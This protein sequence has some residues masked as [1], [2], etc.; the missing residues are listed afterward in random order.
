MSCSH[1][2]YSRHKV[3][4]EADITVPDYNV[5]EETSGLLQND[6]S[7]TLRTGVQ[8]SSSFSSPFQQVSLQCTRATGFRTQPVKSSSRNTAGSMKRLK[9]AFFNSI[10]NSK[11]DS[12]IGQDGEIFHPSPS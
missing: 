12:Q 1:N 7:F 8:F 9:S 4:G 3:S 11:V 5:K 10:E 6:L 2:V